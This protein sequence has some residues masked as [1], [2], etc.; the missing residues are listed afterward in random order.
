MFII[1]L[2][3]QST[4]MAKKYWEIKKQNKTNNK[5]ISETQKIATK[6]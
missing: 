1:K 5:I 6:K 3:D 2:M 4:T